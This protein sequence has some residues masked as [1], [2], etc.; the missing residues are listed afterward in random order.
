MIYRCRNHEITRISRG[1]LA[2]QTYT[3]VNKVLLFCLVFEVD[4]H[5]HTARVRERWRQGHQ[6]VSTVLKGQLLCLSSKL[7][8]SSGFAENYGGDYDSDR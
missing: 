5:F 6:A 1:I 8:S 2:S 4:L 7:I 3:G